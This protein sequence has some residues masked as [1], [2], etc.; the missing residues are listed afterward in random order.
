M[1]SKAKKLFIYIAGSIIFL[2]VPVLFSPAGSMDIAEFRKE[3]ADYLLMLLFFYLNHLYLLPELFYRKKYF[4]FF[5]AIL[6]SFLI[7]LVA[8]NLIEQYSTLKANAFASPFA[9]GLYYMREVKHYLFQFLLVFTV[10]LLISTLSRLR[11]TEKEKLDA[12]LAFLRSQINPHF[13]FNTLNS[14]YSLALTKSNA[15]PTAIVMLSDMMRYILSETHY[16]YVLL[17]KEINYIDSY[18]EL[19]KIRLQKTVKIDYFC[20][21]ISEEKKIA[22]LLLIPFVENA[23]KHGVNP[24]K[25]SYISIKIVCIGNYL[26]LTVFNNKVAPAT[27]SGSTSGVGIK[28]AR[29]RLQMLYAG[30]H[31]LE[32]SENQNYFKIH[33]SINLT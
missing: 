33:L 32:I 26:Q 17:D 21:I 29:Q 2:L 16:E 8:P 11:K 31:T 28:N 4:L 22:P 6:I 5:I 9:F 10:S 24:E 7:V 30:N 1:T 20:Q 3:L 14:V 18:I 23:F 19:Q 13:L 27:N 12:E 25:N 15:A